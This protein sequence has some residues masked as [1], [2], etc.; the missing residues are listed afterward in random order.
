MFLATSLSPEVAP[1]VLDGRGVVCEHQEELRHLAAESGG[2]SPVRDLK[3]FKTQSANKTRPV[4]ND[5]AHCR[6]K[7][8]ITDP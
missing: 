1:V 4:S 5:L 6:N 7:S 8:Q 3:K 2:G